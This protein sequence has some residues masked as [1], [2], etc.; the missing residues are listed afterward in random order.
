MKW[1]IFIS[2]PFGSRSSFFFPSVLLSVLSFNWRRFGWACELCFRFNLMGNWVCVCA[3]VNC[4]FGYGLWVLHWRYLNSILV[5]I[6]WCCRLLM[7]GPVQMVAECGHTAYHYMAV[8]RSQ[9][10]MGSG[11]TL[12]S[13]SLRLVH[14][15]GSHKKY[16]LA[17]ALIRLFLVLS[18]DRPSYFLDFY[19]VF[20]HVSPN[21]IG[22]HC[23]RLC[24]ILWWS[25]IFFLRLVFIRNFR[26]FIGFIL[27][28]VAF[29]SFFQFCYRVYMRVFL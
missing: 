28:A 27:C 20:T 14:S 9:F 1:Y 16:S 29:I 24:C 7:C 6:R 18:L 25:P 19:K 13:I 10:H 11:S 4:V 5:A 26:A 2:I 21:W 23:W 15:V 12:H 17:A 3:R 22:I 8:A